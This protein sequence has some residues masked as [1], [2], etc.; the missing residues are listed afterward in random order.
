MLV[1]AAQVRSRRRLG[2]FKT[3][4]QFLPGDDLDGRHR[5]LDLFT[6]DGREGAAG[7]PGQVEGLGQGIHLE[8]ENVLTAYSSKA[9][10]SQRPLANG[11]PEE[12]HTEGGGPALNG[13]L[14][15]GRRRASFIPG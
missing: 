1:D 10:M 9:R 13:F 3:T 5:Q 7:F 8:F 15:V 4:G 2:A 12:M 14:D 6:D 11:F